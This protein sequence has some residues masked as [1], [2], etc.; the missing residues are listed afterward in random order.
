MK[1]LSISAMFKTFNTFNKFTNNSLMIQCTLIFDKYEHNVQ[2]LMNTNVIEFA[3]IDE[4]IAQLI[5]EK[6]QINLI[7]LSWFKHVNDFDDRLI[8]FIIHVIYFTLIVQNHSKL[9]IFMFITKIDFHFLILDKSWINTHEMMLNMQTNKIIFKID[10]CTNSKAFNNLKISNKRRF[11]SRNI[12]LFFSTSFEK[13]SISIS[14]QKYKILQKRSFSMIAK[15]CSFR[16]TIENCKNE[17]KISFKIVL[18]HNSRYV[19]E[20]IDKEYFSIKLFK[21]K[22]RIKII[23]NS[24]QFTLI[25]IFI[26]KF[27]LIKKLTRRSFRSSK[28]HVIENDDMKFDIEKS[29]NIIFIEVV[30]FQF[31]ANIKSKKKNQ[32]IISQ[33]E[34]V[35]RDHWQSSWNFK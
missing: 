20:K 13:F 33:Y 8:K 15:I 9:A 11:L 27:N 25:E 6:F 29:M 34:A 7:I 3:F 12:Y 22:R 16:L 10:C 5:C 23:R 32:N 18:N 19:I 30:A 26:R 31:L 1:M 2:T 17:K 21:K 14:S 35:E 28:S 24:Q 4:K